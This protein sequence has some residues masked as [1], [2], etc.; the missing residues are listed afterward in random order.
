MTLFWIVAAALTIAVVAFLVRPL[1][2]SGESAEPGGSDLA[3]YRDQ[4]AELERDRARGLVDAGEARSLETEI[5]R[6]MLSAARNAEPVAKAGKPARALAVV[7]AAIIP[8]GA[9]VVYLAVG[10][11]G[12]PAQPLAGRQLSPENDPVKILAEVEQV[13]AKL[14]PVPDDLDK[15]VMVGEAYAKLGRPRDAVEAFRVASGIDPGDTQLKA[16]LAENLIMADGGAVG[17]EAKA[18]FAA[19]PADAAGGPEARFY[20]ALAD[21]QAG[22]VKGALAKWQSL[23]ADSPADAGWIAPTRRR[24]A[25]AAQSLGLDPAKETPEPKPPQPPAAGVP[26]PAAIAQMTPEQQQEM[27]RTMVAALA[28]KLE[29]NPDNANGWRQLARAYRV[30][31][32]EDKAKAALDRAAQVEA[33]AGAKP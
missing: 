4:L 3:V 6:R 7:L 11:P 12:L 31:G 27:I 16:A 33:K 5:S 14:K 32:E 18:I 17:Q 24:I 1:M 8:I 13:R 23:L 10:Q 21:Y 26:D 15:W 30:L 2:R 20:L 19:I 28:A 9:L 25:E 29:A 22:D